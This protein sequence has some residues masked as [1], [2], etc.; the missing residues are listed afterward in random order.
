MRC[1]F[2]P[3]ALPWLL[4][5]LSI[6]LANADDP[7]PVAVVAPA[8]SATTSVL[9]LS[10]S[11]SAERHA[12]LS[13]RVDGLV[14]EIL[15]DAGSRVAED[16]ILLQLDPAIATLTLAEARAASAETRAARDE[17]RRLLDEALLLR[18]RNHIGESEVA[19]RR[20][21]L[22]LAEAALN[23]AQA[24]EETAAEN[25]RRHQLTAP[26]AG[27]IAA[28][29]TDEGEWIARGDAVLELVAL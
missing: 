17:T 4:T 2:R 20:A 26:F 24:R 29:M 16:D 10:G 15:V 5:A 12:N 25:L 6:S 7:V 28:R 21:G 19:T 18:E 27:V 8:V 1:R 22:A 14:A 23:A 13:P 9:R 11:L 3:L